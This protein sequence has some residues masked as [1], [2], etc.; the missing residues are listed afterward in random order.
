MLLIRNIECEKINI[1]VDDKRYF[2]KLKA[3]TEKYKH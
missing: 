3:S 1:F 2:I